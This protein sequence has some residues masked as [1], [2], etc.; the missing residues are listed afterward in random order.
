MRIYELVDQWV[1][2]DFSLSIKNKKKGGSKK[3][4]YR[5]VHISNL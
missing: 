5:L 1:D 3:N 2:D 4:D